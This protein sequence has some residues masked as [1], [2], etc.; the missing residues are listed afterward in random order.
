M[1]HDKAK[2]FTNH[3]WQNAFNNAAQ[4]IDV[5]QSE[6]NVS[7]SL[8]SGESVEVIHLI[9][10]A[11]HFVNLIIFFIIK[12]MQ[13]GLANLNNLKNRNFFLFDW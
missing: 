11:F 9:I 3:W 5:S 6:G 10:F 7:M 8:K 1:G 2:D 4:N 12:L 13:W